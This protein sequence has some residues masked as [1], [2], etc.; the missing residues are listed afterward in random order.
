MTSP[1]PDGQVVVI[2]TWR[3]GDGL[4][5]RVLAGRDVDAPGQEWVFADISSA[6][7]RLAG[8]LGEVQGQQDTA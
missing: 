8:I 5:I 2:R 6:L 1:S 4:L 7:E 3:H